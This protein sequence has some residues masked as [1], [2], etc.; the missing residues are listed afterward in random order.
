M[1]ISGS[2]L[3]SLLSLLFTLSIEYH[4]MGGEAD[5]RAI[6]KGGLMILDPLT[7]SISIEIYSALPT[8]SDNLPL[9]MSVVGIAVVLS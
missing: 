3:Q 7:Y 2:P 1:W 4:V 9:R 5:R 6:E 8:S